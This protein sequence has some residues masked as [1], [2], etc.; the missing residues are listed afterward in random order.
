MGVVASLLVAGAA[1]VHVG[2]PAG[3]T[4]NALA[5]GGNVDWS[6]WGGSID[7][8]QYSPLTQVNASNVSKLGVVWTAQE[9]KTSAGWETDPVVVNGV[10]Y[11]TTQTD[12][13]RAVDATNGKLLWQYTPKVDF[14]KSI[15]GGGGGV[16][17]NRGVTIANG[18]VYL[19]TFDARLIA[20][21][22]ST[23]E[24][25][26]EANVADPSAGYSESSPATYWNG[27]LFVGSEEG[28][29]GLRGFEAAFDATTGKQIWKFYTVPAPG[30]G[31]MSAKGNHGGGD[32]WMPSTIDPSTGLLYFGTGNPS[33]D[34]TN[35]TRPGCNQWADATVAVDAK[36]GKFVWGHTEVCND[37]WDYDSMPTPLAF[38]LTSHGKTMRVVAHAN[39]AGKIWFYDAKTGKVL[40]QSPYLAKYSLP[41][42]KP[43]PA[44]AI[45]CPGSVGGVEYGPSSYNPQTQAVYQGYLNTC[46]NYKTISLKDINAHGQG[47]VD[48]GGSTTFVGKVDGGLAAVDATTGK[49]LW[50]HALSKP[51]GGGG[52]LSTGSGLV[53][54]GGDDGHFYA[55]DAK[56]GN[57]LW[58]ANLGIGFGAA[59]IAYQVKG[60]EYIAIAAG[61]GATTGVSLGAEGGTLVVFKLNG[62]PITK[63]PVAS[64]GASAI[65][66]V[67]PSL[68]GYTQVSKYVYVNAA[69]HHA[70]IQIVAGATADN[71]GFNFD[72]Y[73][74]GQATFTVPVHWSVDIEYKNL[75]ALPHSM[76]IADG[77]TAPAKLETFGFAPVTSANVIGGTINKNFQL[78]GMVADHAGSFYLDCLVPGHLASGMWDNFVVSATATTASMTVTK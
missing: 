35:I 24:K 61:G 7:H 23:G 72:G 5:A 47:Q 22:A 18:K 53:F 20:L 10:L 34:F 49:I 4:S 44:G 36:T 14:Y 58:S 59:P 60:T 40:S 55:F 38:N 62:G 66:V 19:L 67:L 13:V 77:H 26:W 64:A 74:K 30:Q 42:L 50:K 9:S 31:W 71:S 69:Q 68:K 32:V 25:L 76:A 39:K 70:I 57:I 17:Q 52:T 46:V 11:Y 27:M 29:A 48:A 51:L 6:V 8:T 1:G 65:P 73:A 54:A 3:S 43:T 28:D 75:A 37:V 45:A 12:Q 56:T 63:L 78:L 41:H 33:P 2:Q 21:Q 16:P 15:A